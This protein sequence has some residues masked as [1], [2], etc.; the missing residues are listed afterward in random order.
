MKNTENTILYFA[1]T[2]FM[3]DYIFDGYQKSHEAIL[4]QVFDD[5]FVFQVIAIS[6][7]EAGNIDGFIHK[8]FENIHAVTYDFLFKEAENMIYSKILKLEIIDDSHSGTLAEIT[9]II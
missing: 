2:K 9:K 1:G 7:Y 4:A 5:E 3:V 8:E 6:E